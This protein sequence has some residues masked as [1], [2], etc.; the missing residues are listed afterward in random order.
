MKMP[1]YRIGVVRTFDYQYEVDAKDKEEGVALVDEDV[2]GKHTSAVSLTH[3]VPITSE[4][5]YVEKENN[6]G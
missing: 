2:E 6:N 5:T 4:T 3:C 1:L